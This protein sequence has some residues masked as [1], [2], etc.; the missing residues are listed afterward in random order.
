MLKITTLRVDTPEGNH[1]SG[2][3]CRVRFFENKEEVCRHLMGELNEGNS[4]FVQFL[5]EKKFFID[6]PYETVYE[7]LGSYVMYYVNEVHDDVS[8]STDYL[9]RKLSIAN[10]RKEFR[11]NLYRRSSWTPL[12]WR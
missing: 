3:M 10:Y 2:A 6:V 1:S 4:D 8:I 11:E 5:M 12:M 9:D 7:G